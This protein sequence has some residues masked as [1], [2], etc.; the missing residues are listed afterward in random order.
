MTRS[1]GFRLLIGS[2]GAYNAANF[3]WWGQPEIVNS[4]LTS[5]NFAAGQAGAVVAVELVAIAVT[6]FLLAPWISKVPVA[7]TCL[8]ATLIVVAAHVTSAFVRNPAALLGCRL[9][10]GVP[11][12]VLLALANAVLANT[13][14]PDR[15]YALL[16][17]W[18]VA[19]GVL[20]L[21]IIPVVE[22]RYGVR[23]VF[24]AIAAACVTMTPLL[25][26]LPS[27]RLPTVHAV[28]L[29]ER[30]LPSVLSL[31]AMF[32]WGTASAMVWAYLIPIGV[33]AK[34]DAGAAGI[35]AAVSAAGG[36]LGGVVATYVGSR[37]RRFKPFL[38]GLVVHALVVMSITH[39]LDPWTFMV[40]APA[41]L[42][43]VYFLLP[44]FLGMSAQFDQG[45]RLAAAMAG[46]FLLT[47]GTGPLVGGY[48]VQALGVGGI[49]WAMMIGC[50]AAVLCVSWLLLA[51]RVSLSTASAQR[52][53]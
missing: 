19:A 29:P 10:A 1:K 13:Q 47:G 24:L 48:I 17:T 7:S 32:V 18:N 22:Q 51:S 43:C 52:D 27:S 6:A 38:A 14:R 41:A 31:G 9:A 15:S 46:M 33:A 36:L 2:I 39:R 49:G 25:G 50:A 23:G 30:G 40:L 3:S 44:L 4:L 45:G 20:L 34:L 35:V 26:N 12:G 16:N 28:S 11:E 21:M 37:S 42:A 5:A 53:D 8:G